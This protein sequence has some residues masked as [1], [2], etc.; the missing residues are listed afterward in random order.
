ML[1]RSI[2]NSPN[3]VGKIAV[4]TIICI[5]ITFG[6]TN[7][8]FTLVA[9]AICGL[10][11]LSYS[12]EDFIPVL[13]FVLPFAPIFKISYMGTSFFTYLTLLYVILHFVRNKCKMKKYIIKIAGKIVV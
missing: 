10:L 11:M 3:I 2:S 6:T 1:N 4:S 12:E 5:C 8:L 13:F 7:K 9:F